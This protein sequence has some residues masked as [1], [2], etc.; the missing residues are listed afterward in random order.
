LEPVLG[1]G[2]DRGGHVVHG[3][4]GVAVP[5]QHAGGVVGGP[6]DPPLR[7]V[8]V[9]V[10]GVV[11]VAQAFVEAVVVAP[12]GQVVVLVDEGAAGDDPA[13]ALGVVKVPC[14]DVQPASPPSTSSVKTEVPSAVTSKSSANQPG[15]SKAAS[16]A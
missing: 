16:V 4:L 11:G 10:G 1:R 14:S 8:G 2:E 5:D 12:L 3:V 6:G 13:G 15:S 7:A 9:E